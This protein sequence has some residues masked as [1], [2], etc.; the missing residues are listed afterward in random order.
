MSAPTTNT[1][2]NIQLTDQ[3]TLHIIQEDGEIYLSLRSPG[4]VNHPVETVE[5]AVAFT[6]PEL[7]RMEQMG[8][9]KRILGQI[10][11]YHE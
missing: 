5:E 9:S 7:T 11:T 3:E 6:Q 2:M 1:I 10:T 8:R 4:C